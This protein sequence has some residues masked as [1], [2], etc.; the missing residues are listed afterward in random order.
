MCGIVGYIGKRNA[1]AVLIEGLRN[2]EYRGYDSAGIFIEGAGLVKVQ[3]H[4]DNLA[5]KVGDGFQGTA[6]I[7][8]TRWAT[9][10]EPNETN[11]HPHA[12]CTETIHI[13]HNGIIE[14]YRELKDRLIRAGHRL[15]SETDSE[16]IAHLVE[17]EH[18]KKNGGPAGL[19]SFENAVLAALRELNGTYGIAMMSAA[20]PSTIIAA[21]RGSPIV[22]GI[23]DGERFIASDVA[24]LAR[25]T[26]EVDYLEDGEIAVINTSSHRIITLE[27]KIVEHASKKIS[28]N[29]EQAQKGMYDHFM[30]KEIMEGPEAVRAACRGRLIV[31]EGRAAFEELEP[32]RKKLRKIKRIVIVGCGTAYHAG[33]VGKHMIEACAK[34]PAEAAIASEFRYSDPLLD[35]TTA[36]LAISQSGETADTLA[37]VREAKRKGAL[38]IGFVNVVGSTIAREADAAI[39]YHAGP[40]IGVASTKA[41]LSQMATLALFALFL[42]RERG[43]MAS[44]ESNRITEALA[45]IPEKIEHI[46]AKQDPIFKMAK[47]LSGFNHAAFIGRSNHMAIAYEG[48]LK[49]KEISYIHA[50]A[51]AAGEMKHGPLAMIDEQFPTVAI[52]LQDGLYQ[53]MISNLQ[54]IKARRGK[55]FAIAT[56]GDKE[57]AQL[58]DQVMYI[59]ATLAMLSPLLSVVPLQLLAYHVGVLRG[60]NV[61]KPR[62]LAKSVTVE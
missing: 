10:G 37:A 49:L 19:A 34:I 40:E 35:K 42:G 22:I 41:F 51:F 18:L 59:P 26:K 16:V 43:T 61:D 30:L 47:T 31:P 5:Q 50:E 1:T 53:K 48:A 13:V 29:I 6:G 60:Y 25:Y 54:E 24:P 12:D 17:E 55:I 46:L 21:R 2:L 8:H 32:L 15:K 52:A 7:A 20:A 45:L 56:E 33:L 58:A 28:W 23:G 36:V 39:Y 62:N 4:V 9:H 11:A 14:N 27:E 57:I 3:G 38:T 44:G